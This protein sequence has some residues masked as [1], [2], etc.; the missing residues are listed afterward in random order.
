MRS[1]ARD[2]NSEPV[3]LAST[4]HDGAS[5]YSC[6]VLVDDQKLLVA[7]AKSDAM[8]VAI[9]EHTMT[10]SWRALKAT[11]TMISHSSIDPLSSLVNVKGGN[12]MVAGV[13]PVMSMAH[14]YVWNSTLREQ[15][16]MVDVSFLFRD[17]QDNYPDDEMYRVKC[18]SSMCVSVAPKVKVTMLL[19][20]FKV[21][22]NQGSAAH[23]TACA[24]PMCTMVALIPP[25]YGARGYECIRLCSYSPSTMG[26]PQQPPVVY[27]AGAT[28]DE[29]LLLCESGTN[30]SVW[31]KFSPRWS[32]KRVGSINVS[33]AGAEN[34]ITVLA[35]NAQ[36]KHI[37]VGTASGV[38]LFHDDRPQ[39]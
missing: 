1:F 29:L 39:L 8:N 16:A 33:G 12:N 32:G 14:A 19:G 5:K 30:I 24:V 9:I 31:R 2:P 38:F 7:V 22:G 28:T 18:L 3:D 20:L 4:G 25:T 6:C 11:R 36:T 10:S 34:T 15:I 35:A 23:H 13:T 17:E 21:D 27:N 26:I 37:V